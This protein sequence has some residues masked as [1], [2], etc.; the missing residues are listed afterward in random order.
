MY[1]YTAEINSMHVKRCEPLNN[2]CTFVIVRRAGKNGNSSI[3]GLRCG[4]CAGRKTY[5]PFVWSMFLSVR[6]LNFAFS[7]SG[8]WSN[9]KHI[10]LQMLSKP[11]ILVIRLRS[12]PSREQFEKGLLRY[13][14]EYTVIIRS[15]PKPCV[16]RNIHVI[17]IIPR[18]NNARANNSFPQLPKTVHRLEN[19]ASG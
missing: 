11:H 12:K 2:F 17:Q 16:G 7:V 19:F 15:T 5:K 18:K 4:H 13:L 8:P 1:S 10:K 9:F 3:W 14:S 6:S